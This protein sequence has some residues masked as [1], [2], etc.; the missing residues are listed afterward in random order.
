M[1]ESSLGL[2]SLT[3]HEADAP[4]LL[5]LVRQ[6]W[7]IE[8][9]LHYPRD[10]SLREDWCTLRR[11]RAPQVMATLNNLV[12]GLLRRKAVTNVPQARRYY[13]AHLAEAAKLLL[14]S[15]S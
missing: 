3:P 9:R 15:L 12:L 7:P 8:N 4:R 5:D 10:A 13:D 6:H 14:S 11:G 2:T 1:H